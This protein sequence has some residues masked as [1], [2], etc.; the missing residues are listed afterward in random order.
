MSTG[1][2][3]VGLTLASAVVVQCLQLGHYRQAII[4]SQIVFQGASAVDSDLGMISHYPGTNRTNLEAA[5]ITEARR[6]SLGANPQIIWLEVF[7]A[8]GQVIWARICES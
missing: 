6:Y 7:L 1:L 8:D 3:I 5:K 2:A 4:D